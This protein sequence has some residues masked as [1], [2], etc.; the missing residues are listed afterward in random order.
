MLILLPHYAIPIV[1]PCDMPNFP[2]IFPNLNDFVP[3]AL[4]VF[5]TFIFSIVFFPNVTI[6]ALI[7]FT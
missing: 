3:A 1:M 7:S 6:R 5:V 4:K 2:T